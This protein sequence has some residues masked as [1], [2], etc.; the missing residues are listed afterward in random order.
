MN[1]EWMCHE[2]NNAKNWKN[3][4]RIQKEAQGTKYEWINCKL[5]QLMDKELVNNEI[6]WWRME[7]IEEEWN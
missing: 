1:S 7:L 3:Q 2:W 4:E 5:M 6:N